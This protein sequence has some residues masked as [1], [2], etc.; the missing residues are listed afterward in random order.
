MHPAFSNRF[1]SAKISFV[2]IPPRVSAIRNHVINLLNEHM[3]LMTSSFPNLSMIS[4]E[5]NRNLFVSKDGHRKGIYFSS[6]GEDN[7]HFNNDGII[8]LAK[9]LKYLAH[10]GLNL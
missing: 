10:N 3:K 8:R 5:L 6:M 2:N 9:H 4:T 1:Q 7:I